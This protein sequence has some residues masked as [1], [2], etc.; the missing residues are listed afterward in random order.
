MARQPG[1]GMASIEYPTGMNQ[2]GDPSQVW[3]KLK[4]DGHVDV[5]TGTCDL[6][7]GSRTVHAQIAADTIGVPYEWVTLD[8]SNTDSS[9]LC[10]GTFASRGTFVGG[11]AIARAA[12]ETRKSLFDIA[13]EI[14][15]A[16]PADLVSEDG[17]VWPNGAPSAKRS[18]TDIALEATWQRGRMIT[19]QAT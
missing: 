11:N 15:E 10:T 17:F 3:I 19:G 4:P 14:M 13:G 5:F 16:D 2:A 18:I 1:T 9:P 7:Q 8:N 12:V 6:G